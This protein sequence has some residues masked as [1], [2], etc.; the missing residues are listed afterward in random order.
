MKRAA[1][2]A[3]EALRAHREALGN[4][5]LRDLFAIDPG[6]FERFMRAVEV[7]PANSSSPAAS[8]IRI[9]IVNG[10]SQSSGTASAGPIA[11]APAKIFACG[12]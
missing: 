10:A 1:E 11:H 2:A 7:S 6:R 12:M 3:L 5:H 8:L 4:P 9:R